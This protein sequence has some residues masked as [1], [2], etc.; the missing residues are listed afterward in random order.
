MVRLRD[1]LGNSIGDFDL[2]ITAETAQNR[3]VYWAFAESFVSCTLN[4]LLLE[5]S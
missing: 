2:K 1:D 5:S 3:Q 4:R